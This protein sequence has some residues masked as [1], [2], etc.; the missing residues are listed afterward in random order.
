MWTIQPLVITSG[1]DRFPRL[2]LNFRIAA[3]RRC[4]NHH[5]GSDGPVNRYRFQR[6][7]YLNSGAAFSCS[8]V[9]SMVAVHFLSFSA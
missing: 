9:A 1:A 3:V 5:D 7:S 6:P 4:P 2:V 8:S